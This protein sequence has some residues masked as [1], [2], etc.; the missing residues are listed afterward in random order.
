MGII[1]DT[2]Q[3]ISP[4]PLPHTHTHTCV[5]LFQF[6]HYLVQ[7]PASS[8]VNASPSHYPAAAA[9]LHAKAADH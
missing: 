6:V 4:A 8:V 5:K 7:T 2:Q 3:F 9:D 1:P